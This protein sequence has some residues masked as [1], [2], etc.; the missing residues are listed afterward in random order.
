[1]H[2]LIRA[3]RVR[4][5]IGRVIRVVALG[6]LAAVGF[7]QSPGHAAQVTFAWDYSASG[8]AGFAVYCGASS[9]AYTSRYDAGNAL[10]TPGCESAVR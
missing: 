7:A 2:Q 4:A 6:A 3:D 1:M 9:R 10:G 5:A 8:A